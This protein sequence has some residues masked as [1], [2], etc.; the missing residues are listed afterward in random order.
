MTDD[1]T[2][3]ELTPRPAE[4]E[5]VVA[6]RE[7]ALPATPIE[8]GRFSAG[9]QAHTVGLTEERAAEVV[10][11]SSNARSIAF[12]FVLL[13]VLFIPLYWLYDIGLPVL[14]VQP[15]LEKEAEGQ[16]VTDVSRGYALYLA[17]CARCHDNPAGAP[18]NGQGNIGPPLND[19]A[20][21][22]NTITEQGL[23]G[24]GHLNP[25][26]LESVLREGGR[27]VCGD[28]NSVMPAWEEPKGPLNYREVQELIDFILASKDTAFVYQPAHVEGGGTLPPPVN[29][30]GWRDPSYTPAPGATPVP[31]CW[32]G[33]PVG[34]GGGGGGA[35][36]A[37]VESP[38]TADN[39]RV[40][41]V[42]AKG[43]KWVDPAGQPLTA[44]SV[45]DGETIEF[46]IVNDDGFPHNFHIGGA[47]ELSTATDQTDLPGVDNFASGTQTFTYTVEALPDQPQF[48]CTVPGHYSSMNGSLAVVDAGGSGQPGGSPGASG[49]PPSPAVNPPPS[50]AP[51]ASSAP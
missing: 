33:A 11:Q 51:Q 17:N 46:H 40:V 12:L 48:A 14:G 2:G 30:Q 42:H 49:G 38:G 44:I 5:G 34:G 4:P 19:Q 29:V 1:R 24:P 9:E 41:E 36:A 3:R 15:R 22:Y 50:A 35:T 13:F 16:Y 23:P 8:P 32:R 25:D 10:K 45:V 47:A 21:L 43:V 7:P 28:P 39:P 18:G 20:K 37:P 26:Y 31:E 27:Y 6:P